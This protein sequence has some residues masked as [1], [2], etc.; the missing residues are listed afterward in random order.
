MP[1]AKCPCSP[2]Q[3]K[4][5]RPVS[6][7]PDVEAQAG[8]PSQFGAQARGGDKCLRWHAVAQD[9]G[10]AYPV[11]IDDG[12]AGYG[13]TSCGRNQYSLVSG[14][15]AAENH[16]SGHHSSSVFIDDDM[17]GGFFRRCSA[18]V[19]ADVVGQVVRP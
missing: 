17:H 6:A 10:A 4:C 1:T 8:R 18:A 5:P 15:P 16:N 13:G 19:N 12:D 14:R 2:P 3:R 7:I 11:G 9:R